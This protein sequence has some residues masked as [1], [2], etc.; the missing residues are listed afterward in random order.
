MQLN[1]K[2]NKKPKIENGKT[3]GIFVGYAQ[4]P[5]EFKE[6][7][8]DKRKTFMKK[9]CIDEVAS[10]EAMKEVERKL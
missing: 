2:S 3:S 5:S 1:E 8:K 9:E 10:L 7:T 4:L 6:M